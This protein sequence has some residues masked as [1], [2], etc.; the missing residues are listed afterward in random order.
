MPWTYDSRISTF[1]E[2]EISNLGEGVPPPSIRRRAPRKK[3]R[4]RKAPGWV[5]L[6]AGCGAWVAVLVAFAAYTRMNEVPERPDRVAFP[7]LANNDAPL[8]FEVLDAGQRTAEEK[9]AFERAVRKLSPP[10]L[11][12]GL[13]PARTPEKPAATAVVAEDATPNCQKLG[14]RIEFVPEPTE[15]FRLAK[16]Q[17]K[18]VYMVHLSGNF[19]DTAFT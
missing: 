13:P 14:T 7:V 8:V 15:A 17:K 16:Q 6:T 9:A 1:D 10:F 19:E 3:S 18:L 2:Q 12:P 11:L 5:R 4:L